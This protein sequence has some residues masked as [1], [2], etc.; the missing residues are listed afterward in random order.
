MRHLS[1][2]LSQ[3]QGLLQKFLP[4]FYKFEII[5]LDL[6]S[7][8]ANK[9]GGKRVIQGTMHLDETPLNL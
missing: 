9:K 3:V 7:V 8:S 5:L 4:L 2:V 1:S 6:G